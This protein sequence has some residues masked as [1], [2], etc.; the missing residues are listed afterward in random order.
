MA[1][2]I[3]KAAFVEFEKSG[4]APSVEEPKRYTEVINNFLRS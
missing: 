3:Q 4:H 2:L 1:S